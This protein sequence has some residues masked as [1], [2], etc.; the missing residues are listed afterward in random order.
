MYIFDSVK[1]NSSSYPLPPLETQESDHD[2]FLE[3]QEPDVEVLSSFQ[4]DVKVLSSFQSDKEPSIKLLENQEPFKDPSR[5]LTDL[6]PSLP[7][8]DFRELTNL[9]PSLPKVDFRELTNLTPSLP[10][11]DFREL[12]NLAPPFQKVDSRQLTDLA[13]PFVKVDL[14]S[15]FS[16]VDEDEDQHLI[17]IQNVID[18]KRKYLLEKQMYIQ[19]LEKQNKFLREVQND[20]NTY[21]QY[22]VKQRQDQILAMHILNEYIQD[23]AISGKL[24]KTDLEDARQEQANI[25]KEIGKLKGS[26]GTIVQGTDDIYSSLRDKMKG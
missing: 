10:K 14:V 17:N 9:T 1:A 2:P 4:P 26:L 19:H 13:P 15:P 23:L 3:T 25:L 18:Q 20:Y 21:N 7:K 6:T 8:V 12:T 16:K 22:M 5:Q 24:T 11:V